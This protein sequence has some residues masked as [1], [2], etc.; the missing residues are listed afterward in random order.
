MKRIALLS[1][2]LLAVVAT[3]FF[4][5]RSGSGAPQPSVAP[6]LAA[7][8][9][10]TRTVEAVEDSASHAARVV[11]DAP[12]IDARRRGDGP[13]LSGAV[14]TGAGLPIPG[15]LVSW[16]KL[17]DLVVEEEL[18]WSEVDW[19][20]VGRHT[21]VT[22]ADEEGQ[23][24]FDTLAEGPFGYGSALWITHPE[25]VPSV[26]RI[27]RDEISWPR[28]ESC[29]LKPAEPIRVRV[30]DGAG[31]P[32]HLAD[33]ELFALVEHGV[34][35]AEAARNPG[36]RVFRR[37]ERSNIDG[38]ATL[39]RLNGRVALRA[40]GPNAVTAAWEG[41]PSG[42]IDLVLQP[43]FQASGRVVGDVRGKADFLGPARVV[44]GVVDAEGSFAPLGAAS[45]RGD[46][47][48]G[49]VDVLADAGTTYCFRLQG[50]NLLVRERRLS[51]PGAGRSVSIDFEGEAGVRLYFMAMNEGQEALMGGE[52]LVSWE[53]GGETRS[54]SGR[55]RPDGVIPVFGCRPGMVTAL[56]RAPG[57]GVGFFGPQS[58]PLPEERTQ[59]VI[60]TKAASLTGRCTYRG[61]PMQSFSIHVWRGDWPKEQQRYD[62]HGRLDGS[63]EIAEVPANNLS[64]V[65]TAAGV[66]QSARARLTIQSDHTDH[67]ELELSET[68]TGVGQIVDH[69]SGAALPDAQ[70]LAF[71]TAGEARV[72]ASGSRARSDARGWFDIDGLCVGSV[73]VEASAPGH[74]PITRVVTGVR[75]EVL[76]LGTFSLP[77]S[78]TLEVRLVSDGPV[79]GRGY[80]VRGDGIKPTA[81]AENG[82][83]L[84]EGL[85]PGSTELQIGS[86]DG[87]TT[88]VVFL[89]QAD[90]EWRLDIPVQTKRTLR[91]LVAS[92]AEDLP[93]EPWVMLR[94]SHAEGMR[95]AVQ[96][97]QYRLL[98]S[99]GVL[100]T[101]D[102]PD[103]E[104]HA[105]LLGDGPEPLAQVSG[106]FSGRDELELE[107]VI[108]EGM[109]RYRVVDPSGLGVENATLSVAPEGSPGMMATATTDS[110]GEVLL[111]VL[112]PG[113][114]FAQ[115]NHGTLGN[116]I[117]IPVRPSSD[118]AE[119]LDLVFHAPYSLEVVLSDQ[120][121]PAA[122]LTCYLADPWLNANSGVPIL[123]TDT[124]GRVAWQRLG[125]GPYRFQAHHADW[126]PVFVE[127][128]PEHNEPIE[129][130]VR[131][132]GELVIESFDR[133]TAV[134]LP[135]VPLSVRP[136]DPPGD[137]ATWASKTWIELPARGLVT[138][139]Q[140]RLVLPGLARGTYEWSVPSVDGSQ[141]MGLV[142]VLAGE[143][144]RVEVQI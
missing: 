96:M 103:T 130:E 24:A 126:F 15:A 2:G 137:L 104:I 76:D 92:P 94:Y 115:I 67:V 38:I 82:I 48:W 36:R 37:L 3:A 32:V 1:F 5:R 141:Q 113:S 46:G 109:R 44:Y 119:R 106:A 34:R 89:L 70:V 9:P 93:R 97:R 116:Q 101:S 57:Y 107:L 39:P 20:T 41:T 51:S 56:V 29:V 26:V 91:V 121:A 128:F 42:E 105:T 108:G 140:G 123:H 64:V 58:V 19:L 118:A 110:K 120:G 100:E 75:G 6:A 124:G 134:R 112:P 25:Y 66:G 4:V 71:V 74:A 10:L 13:P 95:L 27:G 53:E 40:R 86:L 80:V 136:I 99:N 98:A 65:A 131:R 143:T 133:G 8:E 78:K 60:L 11:D 54:S 45:V 30:L 62:F 12:R 68:V 59:A 50:S 111:L 117:G 72:T 83:A 69:A 63:F 129:I 81:F 18:V 88:Y 47:A 77:R 21:L 102:V 61:S 22:R 79:D 85:G 52:A 23:F 90:E 33:V 49:A 114:V 139:S 142:E 144:V 122:G 73:V 31:Q 28:W 43:S 138:D 135:G 84:V 35:G 55:A 14:M 125:P 87:G 127:A 7:T 17:P 132:R 16:T